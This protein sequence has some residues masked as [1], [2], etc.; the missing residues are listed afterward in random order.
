MSVSW[1]L[2][3]RVPRSS[4]RVR[5]APD[6]VVEDP[7]S[8]SCNKAPTRKSFLIAAD[9]QIVP[10]YFMMRRGLGSTGG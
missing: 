5:L 8:A 10:L 9:P 6:D 1:A 4:H 2:V 3:K 7:D